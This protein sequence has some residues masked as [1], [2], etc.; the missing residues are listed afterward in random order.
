LESSKDKTLEDILKIKDIRD[1]FSRII[2]I[3]K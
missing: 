2:P 1:N 3:L